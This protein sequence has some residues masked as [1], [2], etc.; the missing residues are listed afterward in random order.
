MHNAARFTGRSQAA[1]PNLCLRWLPAAKITPKMLPVAPTSQVNCANPQHPACRNPKNACTAHGCGMPFR[2]N[3]H[4]SRTLP[5]VSFF[6]GF[7]TPAGPE[8]TRAHPCGRHLKPITGAA[9]GPLLG[10][11]RSTFSS[12]IS[13]LRTPATIS[14]S[15]CQLRRCGDV[16]QDAWIPGD[17][18]G[19]YQGLH[20]RHPINSAAVGCGRLEAG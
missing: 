11:S 16:T 10:R 6:E 20:D 17:H 13:R 15:S 3:P 5:A 9:M 18:L 2:S 7:Q 1:K 8:K 4:R 19:L 14:K 12:G